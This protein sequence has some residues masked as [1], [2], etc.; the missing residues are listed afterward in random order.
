[1]SYAKYN[2]PKQD[3]VPVSFIIGCILAGALSAFILYKHSQRSTSAEEFEF[4]LVTAKPSPSD[5]S[6]GVR[7]QRPDPDGERYARFANDGQR[8]APRTDDVVEQDTFPDLLI[9]L[10][11]NL[12]NERPSVS[13]GSG[14]EPATPAP[15]RVDRVLS[16]KN[17]KY[18]L[19]VGYGIA[20]PEKPNEYHLEV[21][22]Q[23]F[24][25]SR[26]PQTRDGW[27]ALRDQGAVFSSS[28]TRYRCRTMLPEPRGSE[29]RIKMLFYVPRNV[30]ITRLSIAGREWPIR[31]VTMG[32]Y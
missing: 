13:D 30:R 8:P 32:E 6:A 31:E 9:D 1:L 15:S 11:N 16:A 27:I 7:N 20:H 28:G 26:W 4:D 22:L 5:T 12:Q 3:A 17:Y 14:G 18:Y 24:E 2:R 10:P 19:F 29:V 21:V 25:R 23:S